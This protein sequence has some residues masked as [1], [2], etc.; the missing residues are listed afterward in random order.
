MSVQLPEALGTIK[1]LLDLGLS[2]LLLYFLFIIWKDRKE[3]IAE[4][5]KTIEQKDTQLDGL[6]QKVIQ[7]VEKNTEVNAQLKGSIDS[8]TKATDTLTDRIFSLLNERKK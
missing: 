6:Q 8:N 1:T 3:I 4:K 5:N 2:G 7:I